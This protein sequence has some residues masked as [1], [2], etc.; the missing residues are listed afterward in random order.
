MRRVVGA[1]SIGA[2]QAW[3]W[4]NRR[5][6]HETGQ[7]RLP[8]LLVDVSEIIRNDA[9]TGIQRVVRSVWADLAKKSGEGFLA[10]P[11]YATRNHGYCYAP[12]D[13]L[14]GRPKSLDQ[15]TVAL[16]PGG[17]FLGLD[18]AAHLL[19]RYRGQIQA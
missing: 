3:L 4:R 19:P 6:F 2:S 1:S 12:A 14:D 15:E 17:R 16:G 9:Q 8:R 13:F 5:R 10:Q 7:F 18:L 11:V